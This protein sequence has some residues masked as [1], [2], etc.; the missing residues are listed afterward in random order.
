MISTI[1]R[2][3]YDQYSALAILYSA[4]LLCSLSG[5]GHGSEVCLVQHWA[6]LASQLSQTLWTS[7]IIN[8]ACLSRSTCASTFNN[9]LEVCELSLLGSLNRTDLTY[10]SL[11]NRNG[12][13]PK[14][15]TIRDYVLLFGNPLAK[16]RGYLSHLCEEVPKK[17]WMLNF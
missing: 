9:V 2:R 3:L 5:W 6:F 10:L 17:S 8:I 7:L 1:C 13:V 16:I 11:L 14:C 15:A 12:K 4:L